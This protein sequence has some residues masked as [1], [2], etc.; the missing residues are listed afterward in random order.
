MGVDYRGYSRAQAEVIVDT[1]SFVVASSVGLG[2]GGETIPYIA[3]WGEDGALEAV[4]EFAGTIDEL[5]RR[6][7]SALDAGEKLERDP[8]VTVSGREL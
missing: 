5:A 1:V 7:E 4:S 6:L 8:A 2:L 3:G